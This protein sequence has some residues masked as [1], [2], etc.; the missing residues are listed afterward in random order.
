MIIDVMLYNS[1]PWEWKNV[2]RSQLGLVLKRLTPIERM[3]VRRD[4]TPSIFSSNPSSDVSKI[5]QRAFPLS[6]FDFNWFT[7]GSTTSAVLGN[8]LQFSSTHKTLTF[9]FPSAFK[10]WT[11]LLKIMYVEPKFQLSMQDLFNISQPYYMSP[12]NIFNFE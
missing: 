10:I 5:F 4:N 8:S 11:T 7:S 1:G 9:S 6:V 12:T 3:N 2:I